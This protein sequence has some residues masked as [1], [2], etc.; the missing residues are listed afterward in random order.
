MRRSDALPAW[1]CAVAV[2]IAFFLTWPFAELPFNDDWSYAFTAR[3]LAQTGH[4]TYNGW[5]A[6]AIIPQAYWGALIIRVFGFSFTALRIGTL[7][8]AMISAAICYLLARHCGL[9]RRSAAF[10]SLTMSLGPMFLPL[11]TSFM[12]D[13]PG[14]MFMLLSLYALIRCA[15]STAPAGQLSWLTTGALTALV[16]GMDRQIVWIVPLAIVPYLMI[17]RRRNPGFLAAAAAAWIVVLLGALATVRWFNAQPYA[18]TDLSLSESVEMILQDPQRL[19]QTFFALWLTTAMLALPAML[20]AGPAALRDLLTRWKS[21]R[22]LIALAVILL[23]AL[24]LIRDPRFIEMPW[25]G[26]MVTPQGIL[27]KIELIG[28]R[29]SVLPRWFRQAIGALIWLITAMVVA[30][31]F[32]SLPHSRETVARLR[33]RITRMRPASLCIGIL[34]ATYTVF[35][36]SRTGRDLVFD[37]YALPLTPFLAIAMLL[38]WQNAPMQPGMRRLT[39]RVA[40]VALCLYALYAIAI[41]QDVFALARARV[42]AMRSLLAVGIPPTDVDDGIEQMAWTQLEAVG[43][44]NNPD[45]Q[46]PPNAYQKGQGYTPIINAV[47]DIEASPDPRPSSLLLGDVE[48]FS[49]LPPFDRRIYIYRAPPPGNSR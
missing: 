12:S 18:I 37:R 29:P 23:T 42:E 36:L 30:D 40:V 15:E 25:L 24:F 39:W 31:A 17:V 7:P 38:W 9:S 19:W 27:G 34:A 28:H 44:I 16:G 13:V 41:T 47:F 11:A 33:D 20:P 21:P 26:N 35:L 4:L 32:G 45:I 14:L 46:N 5:A 8:F 48:Y 2:A 6:P 43:H 49:L 1:G 3:Q 10:A 22:G